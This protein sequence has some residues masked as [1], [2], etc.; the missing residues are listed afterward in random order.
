MPQG[1]D[2][3]LSIVQTCENGVCLFDLSRVGALKKSKQAQRKHREPSSP[4]AFPNPCGDVGRIDPCYP[5]E[6]EHFLDRS[7]EISLGGCPAGNQVGDRLSAPRNGEALPVLN[8]PQQFGQIG[9]GVMRAD[10]EK[11]LYS[12]QHRDRDRPDWPV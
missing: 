12:Q 2:D 11:H 3:R 8:P 5:R 6:F 10:L 1:G 9:L 7:I 4:A